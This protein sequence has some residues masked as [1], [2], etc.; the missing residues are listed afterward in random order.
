MSYAGA[1]A[2]LASFA[3]SHKFGFDFETLAKILRRAG[4]SE[5]RQSEYMQS[6]DPILRLDDAS[7]IASAKYGDKYYSLFVEATP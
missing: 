4:F 7:D 1:G 3:R 2:P 6:E 5:V